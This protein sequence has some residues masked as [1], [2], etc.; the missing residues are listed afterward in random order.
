MSIRTNLEGQNAF[1]QREIG[2]I[3]RELS[4]SK[5][6][7]GELRAKKDKTP[8]EIVKEVE[9][10]RDLFSAGDDEKEKTSGIE[11]MFGKAIESPLVQ[12]IAE[13]VMSNFG[14]EAGAAAAEQQQ[15]PPVNKPFRGADG[16]IYIN[17]GQAIVPFRGRK[18]KRS[19]AAPPVTGADGAPATPEEQAEAEAE[20]AVADIPNIDPGAIAT[21][22]SFMEGAFSRG[23]E[24]EVMAES[25]K[26]QVPGD[27][28]SYIGAHGVDAFLDQVASLPKT[29]PLAQQAGRNWVR[30]L[31]KALLAE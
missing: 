6:E 3:E 14:P 23:T 21:V 20:A 17:N 12:G 8:F 22:V 13:R 29:S 11:R 4:E 1:Q 18:K 7:V 30:K 15:M 10:M 26:T 2:R 28:L 27:V 9:A 19:E 5:K 16:G 25:I 24:P 31:A